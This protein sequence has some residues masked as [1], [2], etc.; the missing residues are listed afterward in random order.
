MPFADF[1][2]TAFMCGAFF[3]AVPGII[4]GLAIVA[5]LY[6][7]RKSLGKDPLIPIWIAWAIG[8]P[9]AGA[10]GFVVKY[11]VNEI[12]YRAVDE[13][14]IGS[15]IDLFPDLVGF[16]ITGLVMGLIG[17]FFTV[18]ILETVSNQNQESDA[19]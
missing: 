18:S 10:I 7:A 17:G 19:V 11:L 5:G 14:F 2:P 13:I 1:I 8:V 9:I 3:W 16:L 6:S 4:G 12:V 15:F